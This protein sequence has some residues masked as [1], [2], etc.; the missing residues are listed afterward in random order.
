MQSL[1]NAN[2]ACA[3]KV[4]GLNLQ[5]RVQGEVMLYIV[6]KQLCLIAVIVHIQYKIQYKIN[7]QNKIVDGFPK[8]LIGPI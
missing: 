4:I 2:I 3:M 7:I 5:L 1:F 8:L 6:H